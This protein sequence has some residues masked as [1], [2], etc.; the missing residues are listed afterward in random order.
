MSLL[1]PYR[2]SPGFYLRRLARLRVGREILRAARVGVFLL[3]ALGVGFGS[4]WYMIGDGTPLT[5]R[6]TGPW[7]QWKYLGAPDTDPY[8][9]ARMAR[10]GELP[11]TFTHAFY[12][13]AKTDS[14]GRPL[15]A[16]CRY[17][18]RGQP[19]DALWWSLAVYDTQGFL[20]ANGTDRYSLNSH[21]ILRFAD[22]GY[23][24]FL[25]NDVRPGNWLPVKGSGERHLLLRLYGPRVSRDTRRG[26]V[27][28]ASLPRIQLE[29]CS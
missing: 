24:I 21:E 8:T 3:L 12:F 27:I 19:L 7:A 6:K 17:V 23:R 9:R 20:Q 15:R 13:L 2:S 25:G 11:V 28:E 18:L 26:G 4:A 22:G 10:T 14:A 1:T 16:E 5:T 29:G